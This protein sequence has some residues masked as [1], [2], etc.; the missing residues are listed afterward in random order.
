[1]N[2]EVKYKN[3][4][5]LLMDPAYSRWIPCDEDTELECVDFVV[6]TFVDGLNYIFSGHFEEYHKDDL[7][8]SIYD[9]FIYHKD[10]EHFQKTHA[11]GVLGLDTGRI[12]VY[13]LSKVVEAQPELIESIEKKK[14]LAAIIKNFSGTVSY[15]IDKDGCF[16][17]VGMSDDGNHDFFTIEL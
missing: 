14:Y 11:I 5:V 15:S 13:D 3:V 16:H 2:K 4:D 7:L 12:G 10:N 8:S 9:I 1:M 6:E 17:V